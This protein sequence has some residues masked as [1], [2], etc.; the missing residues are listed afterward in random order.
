SR[1]PID[2]TFNSP[3]MSANPNQ[4]SNHNQSNRASTPSTYPDPSI[5]YAHI[6][7]S[8]LSQPQSTANQMAR[9]PP[10][11]NLAGRPTYHNTNADMWLPGSGSG[12][13]NHELSEVARPNTSDDLD[14][15]A[16]VAQKDAQAKR[17]QIPPFVQKLSRYVL[18]PSP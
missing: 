13:G 5:N 18:T 12:H 6:P 8:N 9:R 2:P 17:K 1:S 4:Y 15:R 16:L 3:Q 14:Q 11:Q 7:T 10:E